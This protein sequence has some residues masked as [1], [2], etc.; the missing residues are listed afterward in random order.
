M[1]FSVSSSS[2]VWC[3][4]SKALVVSFIQEARTNI[5]WEL[6]AISDVAVKFES[7][8]AGWVAI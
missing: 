7:S 1:S 8:V 3:S 5:T 4:C 6:L 2:G